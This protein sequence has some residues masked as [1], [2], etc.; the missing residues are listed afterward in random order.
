MTKHVDDM[1][2]AERFEHRSRQ[3]ADLILMRHY[4]GPMT[5]AVTIAGFCET[6]RGELLAIA[7]DQ[8]SALL[9]V[10]KC[11]RVPG[12]PARSSDIDPACLIHIPTDP[13]EPTP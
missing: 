5:T 12:R 1:N 6:S 2:E 4:D 8:L 9:M 13:K 3:L 7:V 11:K 10:C